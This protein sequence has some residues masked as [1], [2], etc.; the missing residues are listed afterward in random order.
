MANREMKQKVKLALICDKLAF[1]LFM[2]YFGRDIVCSIIART[3]GSEAI[4][5]TYNFTI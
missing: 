5:Y 3:L 1:A 2:L 4:F